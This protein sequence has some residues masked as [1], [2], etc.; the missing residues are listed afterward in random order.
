MHSLSCAFNMKNCAWEQKKKNKKPTQKELT[1]TTSR[2]K[3]SKRL[4]WFFFFFFIYYN[5]QSGLLSLLL[6]QFSSY[7]KSSADFF[8]SPYLDEIWTEML[9]YREKSS[10]VN[11]PELALK[12]CYCGNIGFLPFSFFLFFV[13]VCVWLCMCFVLF[14]SILILYHFTMVKRTV[15]YT[16]DL[17][18][19][20]L[21]GKKPFTQKDHLQKNYLHKAG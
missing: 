9:K 7:S 15:F 5:H 18:L 14:N 6:F 16:C 11:F 12:S 19:L 20:Y 17:N 1:K 2:R 21:W 8:F 3:D 10:F 13:C 4:I